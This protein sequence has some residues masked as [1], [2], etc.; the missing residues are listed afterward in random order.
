MAIQ[1]HTTP[2]YL[3]SVRDG[4][5][6]FRTNTDDSNPMYEATV[7]KVPTVKRAG[8]AWQLINKMIESSG[9]VYDHMLR[10]TGAE[11]TLE[12]VELPREIIAKA[13][14]GTATDDYVVVTKY[15]EGTEFALGLCYERRD[16]TYSMVWFPRCKLIPGEVSAETST[17]SDFPDP[18]VTYTIKAMALNNGVVAVWNHQSEASGEPVAPATFFA[19]P[20]V[21]AGEQAPQ[22]N[23]ENIQPV[24]ALPT[25]DIDATAVYV[26]T[27]EDGERAE[28]TMWRYINSTWVEYEYEG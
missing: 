18:T 13:E 3:V 21:D 9:I 16:G 6:C 23:F 22:T 12:V 8:I 14:P 28:G 25:E 7:H 20:Q 11:I 4:Y 10:K 27:A 26:L 15:V 5:F 2:L 19:A 17:E 1:D 24:A